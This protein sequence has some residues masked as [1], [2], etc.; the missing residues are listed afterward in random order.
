M[1]RTKDFRDAVRERG[2]RDPKF[3][4]ALIKEGEVTP[5]SGSVF[6]DM[7]LPNA[8]KLK[9]EAIKG[10]FSGR[11]KKPVSVADMDRGIEEAVS[12][13]NSAPAARRPVAQK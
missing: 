2:V 4:R 12:D 8:K 13:E 7:G 1:G 11:V 5:S 3:R 6:A 10:M 9:A